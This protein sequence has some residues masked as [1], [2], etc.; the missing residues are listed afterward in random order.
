MVAIPISM[1]KWMYF[2]T[3]DDL[4]PPTVRG[5]YTLAWRLKDKADDPWTARIN[6]FK[7]GHSAA[8]HVSGHVSGITR[9]HQGLA[10]E[11]SRHRASRR[12]RFTRHAAGPHETA[13][14]VGGIR[15]K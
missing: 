13:S 7:E 1:A 5:V 12:P 9:P 2:D 6:Q 3:L 4:G 8:G 14:S 11:P 15:S 10:M